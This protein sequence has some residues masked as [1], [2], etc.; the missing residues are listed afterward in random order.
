M[1]GQGCNCGCGKDRATVIRE[2]A[3]HE[4]LNEY[5]AEARLDWANQTREV[6]RRERYAVAT[7]ETED[8]E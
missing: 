1:S 4:N 7:I 5:Q 3:R 2:I 6:G 8:D